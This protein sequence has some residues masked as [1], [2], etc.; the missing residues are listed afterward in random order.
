M[1]TL[2]ILAL[3]ALSAL[4]VAQTQEEEAIILNQ[5]LQY[6]EESVNNIQAA[7]ER[8]SKKTTET[9]KA[10]NEPSLE[11]TYFGEDIGED[12]VNTRASGP[13]RRSL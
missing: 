7:T 12:T 5:E 13:R 8:P 9:T 1:R 10:L 11:R 4:A 6:L 2:I 3:A